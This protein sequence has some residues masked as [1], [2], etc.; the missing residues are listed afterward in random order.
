MNIL[1]KSNSFY[2][3]LFIPAA[4]LLL[5]ACATQPART[6]DTAV[7][8]GIQ[9]SIDVAVEISEQTEAEQQEETEDLLDELIPSLSLDENLL[10]PIEDRVSISSPNL[11]AD[12]FFNALVADTDYG[13]AIS[14]DVDVTINLSLPNVTIEEAMDTVA[15]IYNLDITRRGNIYTVRPGVLFS[16][17][18]V[19]PVSLL[20]APLP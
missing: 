19:L 3:W 15:E 16:L 4:V 1:A 7:L 11:T 10:T 14:E 6:P 2:R 18:K 5:S 20:L 13:V 9:E 12:V 17:R 8:A